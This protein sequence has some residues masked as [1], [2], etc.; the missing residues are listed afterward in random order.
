[1]PT[2]KYLSEQEDLEDPPSLRPGAYEYSYVSNGEQTTAPMIKKK[3]LFSFSSLKWSN[4]KKNENER[5]YDAA[6]YSF[7]PSAS[8]PNSTTT[9]S[10]SNLENLNSRLKSFKSSRTLSSHHHAES[11]EEI[12]SRLKI[13]P[14]F[15][16]HFTY[17]RADLAQLCASSALS[18][19][20]LQ[21]EKAPGAD[22]SLLSMEEGGLNQNQNQ[23]PLI[24]SLKAALKTMASEIDTLEE[25]CVDIEDRYE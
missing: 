21:L 9:L 2:L 20:P 17:S 14:L 22:S 24:Q 4:Q 10:N 5:K 13:P 19:S 18:S 25:Q 1:M 3:S 23:N 7:G 11:F 15:A 16:T 12:E 8:N 6:L